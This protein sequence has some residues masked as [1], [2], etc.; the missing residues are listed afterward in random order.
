MDMNKI[1]QWMDLAKKYQTGDFWDGIFDQSSFEEFMKNNFDSNKSG[2][3]AIKRGK[4]K[5]FLQ[6]IFS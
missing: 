5:S 1:L 4:E 6:Q 2:E 3:T